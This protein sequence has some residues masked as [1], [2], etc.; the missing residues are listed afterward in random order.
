MQMCVPP[1]FLEPRWGF[2]CHLP[3]DILGLH[4][5]DS[6]GE[7]ETFTK[8]VFFFLAWKIDSDVYLALWNVFPT[9]SQQ[10]HIPH[11]PY[12]VSSSPPSGSLSGYL[13]DLTLELGLCGVCQ[14]HYFR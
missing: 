7:I 2:R 12:L 14:R 13:P 10:Y 8:E 3:R 11:L 6:A 5:S 9:P 4:F 1:A